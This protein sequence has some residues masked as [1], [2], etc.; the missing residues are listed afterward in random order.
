VVAFSPHFVKKLYPSFTDLCHYAESQ[1]PDRSQQRRKYC[2]INNPAIFI[3]LYKKGKMLTMVKKIWLTLFY[4][5]PTPRLPLSTCLISL[6]IYRRE[7]WILV[8]WRVKSVL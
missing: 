5:E 1:P 2:C 4:F 8:L 3:H 7:M 6:K